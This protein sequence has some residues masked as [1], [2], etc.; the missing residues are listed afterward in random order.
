MMS[1]IIPS[2]GFPVKLLRRKRKEK[3]SSV[4]PEVE[5]KNNNTG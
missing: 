5:V 2:T 3:Q 1:T 4:K